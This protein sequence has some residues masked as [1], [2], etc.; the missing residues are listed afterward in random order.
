MTNSKDSEAPNSR[1]PRDKSEFQLPFVYPQ[2]SRR[3]EGIDADHDDDWQLIRLP[4]LAAQDRMGI[5]GQ[6][7]SSSIDAMVSYWSARIDESDLGCSW[8]DAHSSCWRCGVPGSSKGRSY[9]RT[10][11]LERCH[12]VPRMLGG[13]GDASNLVL[14]C[15][16][17]HNEAPDVDDT[18]FMWQWIRATSSTKPGDLWND[19]RDALYRQIWGDEKLMAG[20]DNF[21]VLWAGNL[22]QAVIGHPIEEPFDPHIYADRLAPALDDVPLDVARQI[23][24][25]LATRVR[26]IILAIGLH[27]D[28]QQ[29]GTSVWVMR[30]TLL[31]IRDVLLAE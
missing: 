28:G 19:R 13:S 22:V 25:E 4:V 11:P 31:A 30:K 10:P 16:T 29:Y 21:H 12:I 7:A 14:L 17:C 1:V 20:L 18:E 9:G 24:L 27:N 8:A 2:E 15:R 6:A 5:G 26:R 3:S 23:S